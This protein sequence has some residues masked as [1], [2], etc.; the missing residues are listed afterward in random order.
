MADYIP[1]N[2]AGF[3]IWQGNDITTIS[4]NANIWD[5]PPVEITTLLTFQSSWVDSFA[6][7]SNRLNRTS[8]DVTEKDDAREVYQKAL[9]K[10]FSQYI[11][12]NT[13]I[14]NSDRD[15]LGLNVKSNTR[16]PT[17]TPA[18][19]PIASVDFSMHMQH[20]VYF[21]DEN[22]QI[23]KAKPFGVH[24]CEIWMKLGAEAPKDASE[25]SYL[26]TCTSTPYVVHFTGADAGKI[27]WYW[28][29]WTNSTNKP[30]PWASTISALVVG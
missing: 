29:R 25:L 7:A 21:N 1:T 12:N 24:G 4:T 18:S 9:R 23:S 20:K 27:A 19:S 15:R 3:N 16:I 5:I 10:F 8:A 17:P 2:D 30:G 13:K 11:I 26:T 14:S 22:T 28:L 6:K